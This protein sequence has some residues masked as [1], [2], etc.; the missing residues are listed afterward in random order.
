[1][2]SWA[3]TTS[4]DRP[5]ERILQASAARRGLELVAF[6]TRYSLNGSQPLAE[7]LLRD[8][9]R[10]TA[11]LCLSDSIAYGVYSACRVVGLRIP[12]DVSVVGFDDH[13]L[14]RLVDPALTSVHWDI[15]HVAQVAVS[16]VAR[17]LD[18]E[19]VTPAQALI[20]PALRIRGSTAPTR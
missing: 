3:I 4:P 6:A 15:D 16:F 7:S 10:P 8:P 20:R 13:P 12:A 9:D 17:A 18:R 14:S 19:H 2:L 5:A 11:L 1:M